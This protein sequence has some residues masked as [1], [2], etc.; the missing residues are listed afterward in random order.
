ME[1]IPPFSMPM[2]RD[3]VPEAVR[4]WIYV[5]L[6]FCFQLSGGVYMGAMNDMIGERSW[7][8]E[9]V[10]MLLYC[11]LAGM[12]VW[13]PVMF[14]MKFRFTNKCLL[15]TSAVVI[16]AGNVLTMLR[17]PLPVMGLV[18]VL[19]GVAK[20]QGTFECM[21]N[22]QLW[23]TPKRDFA[24]FFPALH[25]ILL[26]A[27]ELTGYLSAAFAFYMHWTMMHVFVVMLM[28]LVITV[29]TLLCRP[30][31]PMPVERRVPLKG[32]DWTGAVLWVA[33]WL[34][35]AWV[36]NYGD[37]L[38]WFHSSSVTVVTAMACVTLAANM[39]RMRIIPKPYVEWRIMR[40]RY[41]RPL[42]LFVVLFE[43]IISVENVLEMVFYE[44]V[45]HYSDLTYE[46]LNVWSLVGAVAGCGFSLG[47]LKLMRWSQYRL[48]AIGMVFIGVYCMGFYFLVSPTVG[49]YQL[50]PPLI[51]R[52]FG[53]AVLCIAFMWS[54]HQIMS[55]EHFFQ[56]LCIFNFLHM[57]G[58]GTI[59]AAILAKGIGVYVADGFARV[60]DYVNMV[61]FSRHP[62]D[63]GEYMNGMVEVLLCRTVK[64]L[65]GW[66]IWACIFFILGFMLWDSPGVR[67]HVKR[68]PAWSVVGARTLNGFMKGQ[69]ILRQRVRKMARKDD[70]SV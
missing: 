67:R 18:C 60:G 33:F 19:C 50:V 32:I 14:R 48:I 47:W 25:V 29:Q 65:Y 35:V 64:I 57:F 3:W 5:V 41:L 4:P 7:M 55:F 17:L 8:R 28:L 13:F 20:I 6:A 11:S 69:R 61:I 12:A 36:L 59:G 44:E 22:I 26:T 68:M 39:I 54:L 27:I 62:F 24:V 70:A 21:S 42:L 63:F 30:F 46:T 53:Y 9:D 38:D 49:Y 16:M 66:V 1:K 51:C 40:Y 43:M 34:E 15:I 31:C 37:W 56:S 58:G 45:M 23:I 10:I 52:G 2:F